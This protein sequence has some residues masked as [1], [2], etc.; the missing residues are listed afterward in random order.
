VCLEDPKDEE[1]RIIDAAKQL[2]LSNPRGK[3][4][5]RVAGILKRIMQPRQKLRAKR[6]ALQALK[7]LLKTPESSPENSEENSRE[8]SPEQSDEDHGDVRQVIL[9]PAL[10]NVI[11]QI[12]GNNA[13]IEEAF[14]IAEEMD[15][16]SDEEKEIEAIEGGDNSPE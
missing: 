15:R 3:L 10:M 14:G 12:H 11:Q 2:V 16:P 9:T 13:T 7:E 5:K 1:N 4:E 6:N 8:S